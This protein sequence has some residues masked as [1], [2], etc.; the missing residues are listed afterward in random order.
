VTSL[1]TREKESINTWGKAGSRRKP[2][3]RG[4]EDRPPL[5]EE[6]KEEGGE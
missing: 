4:E 6:R 2:E 1:G 3:K 5:P